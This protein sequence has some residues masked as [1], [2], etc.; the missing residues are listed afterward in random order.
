MAKARWVRPAHPQRGRR[1]GRGD[2]PDIPR[3]TRGLIAIDGDDVDIKRVIADAV[4]QVTPIVEAR[5][6]GLIVSL[7]AGFDDH[8]VKPIDLSKVMALLEA[9]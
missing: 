7:A 6:H 3:V 8:L 9:A 2:P 1:G 5:R 4:E